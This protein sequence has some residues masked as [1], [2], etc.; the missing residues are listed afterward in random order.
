MKLQKLALYA[1]MILALAAPA[2]AQRQELVLSAAASLT[3][4]LSALKPEAEKYI[5]AA[6]VMNFGGSGTLR[7]QIEQGAP[8]D[9]FFS[10]ASSDMDKLEKARLI[11]PGTRKDLLSNAIVLV[12]DGS[13]RP[14]ASV[15]ELRSLLSATNLVAIGNPDSVPAGRYAVEAFT[16]LGLYPIVEKKLVLGGNVRQVLQFVESGSAPLGVVFLTDAASVA[17]NS[18][19]VRLYLFPESALKTPVLYP[20]AVVAASRNR[21]KAAKLIAFFQ[22][23]VARRAFTEAGFVVR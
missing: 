10:A 3:D 16:S 22:G 6:I 2:T 15:D 14:P 20:A 17:P 13:Q 19:V 11:A 5:D 21:D 4:V 18:L 23:A 1:A 8:V 9:L 7:A 12:G